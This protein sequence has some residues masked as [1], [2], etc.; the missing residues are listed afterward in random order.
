MFQ[1][2][3]REFPVIKYAI[4]GLLQYKDMHGYRIKDHIERNFGHMWSINYGQIYSNLKKLSDEGLIRMTEVVQ[5]DEKGPPRKL[6]SSTEKGRG[7]FQK[8]LHASPEKAMLLRDPFLMRFVFYAF[9]DP[10]RAIELIDEQIPR[11]QADLDRRE[12]N[13][14]RWERS[15]VFVKLIAELGV[16]FNEMFLDWLAHARAEI[17]KL[18]AEETLSRTGTD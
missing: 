11:Y 3:K 10:N 15:N 1:T 2:L 4:L 6:Y 8:W 7:A 14:E 13:L 16:S 9:G 12:K 17:E 5:N 18:S